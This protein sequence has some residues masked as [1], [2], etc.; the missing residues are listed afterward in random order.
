M[1]GSTGLSGLSILVVGGAGMGLGLSNGSSLSLR[2]LVGVNTRRGG[3]RIVLVFMALYPHATSLPNHP[4][5]KT[6]K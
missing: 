6:D 2:L 3:R 5:N 4:Q 1:I